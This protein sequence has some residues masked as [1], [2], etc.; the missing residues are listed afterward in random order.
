MSKQTLLLVDGDARSLRVL[1]VSLRKAGF[2]VTTAETVRDAMDKLLVRAPELIISEIRFDDGDGFDL[3][4]KVRA[5]E[6]WQDIPF[7]FLTSETAIEYKIKGL[8]LGVDDYLT[9]PIYIKEIVARIGIL[10]Q[11]KQRSRIEERKDVR[12]RFVGRLSDMPVVD[13]IQT[14]EVSRKSG[15]IQFVG[16]RDQQAAIYFRDGK[17][18]DA[19]AGALQGEDAVYRLLTW[20]DGD[21]EV[22][23]RTV[24]RREVVTVSSQGLLM[25]GMR[26]LD[27]WTLLLE[28]LPSLR[29]K[30]EVDTDE[31]VARLGDIPDSNNRILRLI[32]GKRS[33]I[34]VIDA[35]DF[36]DLECLQVIARLYFEGLL[37]DVSAGDDVVAP[38]RSGRIRAVSGP[39]DDYARASRSG[40]IV[41]QAPV[42]SAVAPLEFA[43]QT[44]LGS[45]GT[46]TT[47]TP[48]EAQP[49][50][51][52]VATP[53]TPT[54]SAPQVTPAP[55][56]DQ[57]TPAPFARQATPIMT[58]EQHDQAVLLAKITAAALAPVSSSNA[59]PGPL[60]GGIRN[61]S[62]RL[63]DEAV[64]AAEAI[65]PGFAIDDAEAQKWWSTQPPLSSARDE[66]PTAA[67]AGAP[68]NIVSPTAQV[69]NAP[70]AVARI[71]LVKAA[72]RVAMGE[73]P[74]SAGSD[75]VPMAGRAP[76]SEPADAVP[77]EVIDRTEDTTSPVLAVDSVIAPVSQTGRTETSAMRMISSLGK[78]TAQVA[79][80][81]T[82]SAATGAGEKDGTARQMVTILPRRITREIPASDVAALTTS[83]DAAKSG[84][85]VVG[86]TRRTVELPVPASTVNIPGGTTRKRSS[87]PVVAGLL[88]LAGI[89]FASMA[90]MKCRKPSAGT[91]PLPQSGS[92]V[93]SGLP[94]VDAGVDA[95]LPLDASPIA[96]EVID[97]SPASSPSDAAPSKKYRELLV[98]AKTA[99][100]EGDAA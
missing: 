10:L 9:K 96:V 37:V 14:I 45:F 19:E 91:K 99:L 59:G 48:F 16:E 75:M 28:Q 42:Q 51:L 30:F 24:R 53:T 86:S 33:L 83:A 22:M 82:K 7:V 40:Q 18:I 93:S 4:R 31:L 66:A 44:T 21:F 69:V 23:F 61:S 76:E 57:P 77:A 38:K 36:G 47:P 78:E 87:G 56:D 15:V 55:F 20:S 90:Y 39:I 64:A 74:G 98:K 97:A 89:L 34:E 94:A 95:P 35:C 63:I 11:K 58:G 79:G 6:E 60:L 88:A 26:R 41:L 49:T 12:T 3:R 65:D 84:G 25:E 67:A 17:V 5:N 1:E 43:A 100:D 71:A 27:E 70:A 68:A 85:A 92:Q 80:E 62:L 52:A 73:L 2:L 46:Q 81:V 29:A 32:D 13:V 50:P 8:E 54:P 72:P